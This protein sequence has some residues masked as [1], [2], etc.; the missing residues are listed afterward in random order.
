M[1]RKM[2]ISSPKMANCQHAFDGNVLAIGRQLG[3]H[4]TVINRLLRKHCQTNNVK[5]VSRSG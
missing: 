3:Y 2:T 4:Y 1:V 5:N